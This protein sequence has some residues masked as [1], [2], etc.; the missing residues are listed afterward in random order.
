MGFSEHKRKI[1][2]AMLATGLSAGVF[3]G[4]KEVPA[5]KA[6]VTS[7]D[8]CDISDKSNLENTRTASEIQNPRAQEQ[9]NNKETKKFQPHEFLLQEFDDLDVKNNISE[10]IFDQKEKEYKKSKFNNNPAIERKYFERVFNESFEN[11]QQVLFDAAQEFDVPPELLQAVCYHESGCHPGSVNEGSGATGYMQFLPDTAK[12][13][14]LKIDKKHKIDER[15][16]L[17]KSARAAAQYLS[18][19]HDRF[20]QWGL[21][22][23]AYS[24]GGGKLSRRLRESFPESFP[25]RRVRQDVKITRDQIT[26]AKKAKKIG[27]LN[28]LRE[29]M[30][31]LLDKESE[32]SKTIPGKLRKEGVNLATAASDQYANLKNK[33]SVEYAFKVQIMAGLLRQHQDVS[34]EEWQLKIDEY[35]E[36][37]AKKREKRKR[38][39]ASSK[40][41]KAHLRKASAGKVRNLAESSRKH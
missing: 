4:E 37:A 7:V 34:D 11:K 24:G 31:E 32:L 16:D 33:G 40:K 29:K 17:K 22:L 10:P 1:A 6:R 18:Q 38:R 14:G 13:M 20:G 2:A 39:K 15:R 9:E 27:Y 26:S 28:A 41:K 36:K 35:N 30:R 5:D 25:D 19:L 3:A 21:A 23:V 12:A 8:S